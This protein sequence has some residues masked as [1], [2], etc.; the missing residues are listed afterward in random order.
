M[1]TCEIIAL[2]GSLSLIS[3]TFILNRCAW[4]WCSIH[5]ILLQLWIGCWNVVLCWCL[6][7]L[8]YFALFKRKFIRLLLG[9]I[10]WSVCILTSTLHALLLLLGYH[11]SA[12]WC[13]ICI[14]LLLLLLIKC[15]VL[16]IIH[17]LNLNY[18]NHSKYK[19]KNY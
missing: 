2:S 12:Y 15:L 19:T 3:L 6:R 13:T 14:C 11:R 18:S 7:W 9:L 17:L 5:I 16:L 10:V 4:N 1:P 8:S